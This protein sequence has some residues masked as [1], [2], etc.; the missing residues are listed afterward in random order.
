VFVPYSKYS[1]YLK[2][3]TFS[4]FSYVAVVFAVDIP[5]RTVALRTFV[6]QCSASSDYWMMLVAVIGTTIS[7]YLFFWQASQEVE[8]MNR[9]RVRRPLKELAR[10]GNPELKRIAIDTS[11]GMLFSN[12][13]AFSIVLTTAA[14]LNGQ[15]LTNIQTAADAAEALRPVA[16]NFA[17]ALF[18]L[19][20]VGTG[21]L[22]I[23]VLAGSGAYAVAEVFGWP[24]TLEAK[25]PEARG[26][27]F[28]ILAG[29]LIG[30]GLGF[31]SLDPI[32]ML[33]WSA[34]INGVVSVPIMA[35]MM[36]LVTNSSAMGRFKAGAEL[37]ITGWIATGLMALV[38]GAMAV[39]YFI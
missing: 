3:L 10:G 31:T 14:T 36:L 24:S 35:M 27:Y 29:T 15:G 2:W 38:V 7:P 22:A 28:I 26:F 20:I 32:Q 12:L 34:V 30:F 25:F 39:S 21:L 8:E 33:I 16:G 5:W 17:F 37:T 18:A 13:V 1:R 6:P 23:P 11:I 4:L 19:G 9:G